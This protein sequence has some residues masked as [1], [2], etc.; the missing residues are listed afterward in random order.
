MDRY[1]SS[2]LPVAS[3]A[4]I[5]GRA[6]IRFS[7]KLLNLM[8]VSRGSN[9]VLI[10]YSARRHTLQHRLVTFRIVRA[11]E[12]HFTFDVLVLS[13]KSNWT[14]VSRWENPG[15]AR[16]AARKLVSDKKHQGVK[17]MQEHYDDDENRFIEK[18][19]FRHMK[20][21]EAPIEEDDDDDKFMSFDDYDDYGEGANWIV[22]L[23]GI[24]TLI[25]VL[26]GVGIYFYDD[27][28][29]FTGKARP[30]YFVYEL[31]PVLTN[32][33]SGEKRISVKI[34]LQLELNNSQDSKA[35]EFALAQIME[36]VIDELQIKNA[37]DLMN[38]KSVELLRGTLQEKIQN[39][40]GETDL[41]GAL[42]KDIQIF[43]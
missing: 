17:V 38:S 42:F 20:Q 39:A 41:Q 2:V 3:F 24:V 8:K 15:D 7:A 30:G 37:S 43:E 27:K 5:S 18:T 32:V 22:P 13:G 25:V 34:N 4:N 16:K 19:I 36:S 21:D 40:M 29:N 14:S 35:V 33:T 31:P 10:N 26:L 12:G 6:F 23:A 1:I 11:L 28:M 9:F